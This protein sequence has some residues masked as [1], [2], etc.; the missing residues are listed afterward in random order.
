M[1]KSLVLLAFV[2][3]PGCAV[4]I[5]HP[6]TTERAHSDADHDA[7]RHAPSPDHRGTS[8]DP[9]RAH[10]P[11]RVYRVGEGRTRSAKRVEIVPADRD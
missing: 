11:K 2:L 1:P 9:D 5:S 4:T 7:E 8:A 3:L 10:V 6:R